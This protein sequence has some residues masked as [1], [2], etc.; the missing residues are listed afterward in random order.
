MEIAVNIKGREFPDTK[1]L[2]AH[3]YGRICRALD[4]FP[5]A[6]DRATV[7]V[8]GR[9]GHGSPISRHQRSPASIPGSQDRRSGWHH[10][11]LLCHFCRAKD[12]TSSGGGHLRHRSEGAICVSGLEL[13]LNTVDADTRTSMAQLHGNGGAGFDQIDIFYYLVRNNRTKRGWT[14]RG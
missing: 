12:S 14:L 9:G 4:G 2:K 11:A 5:G 8:S 10:R 7:T 3:A 1:T 13:K 6:A